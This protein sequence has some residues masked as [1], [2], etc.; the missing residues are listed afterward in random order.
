L[1]TFCIYEKIKS[2]RHFSILHLDPGHPA[3]DPY[4]GGPFPLASHG[5]GDLFVFIFFGLVA[6]CGTYYVQT[7][8]LTPMVLV[9]GIIVGLM[10]T[11]ILVVNNLRDIE[12]D[13]RAGKRTLAVIIGVRA[14]RVEYSL[15]HAVAYILPIAIWL[16]DLAEGFILFPPLS[17]TLAIPLN[18]TIWKFP[19]EAY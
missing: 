10:I 14:T 4:S 12:T 15:L 13:Q 17:L 1:F 8:R 16:G 7:L 11:S 5:L 6:V 18:R 3:Q 19:M 2:Y 9:M